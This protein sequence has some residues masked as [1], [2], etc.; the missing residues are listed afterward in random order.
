LSPD[1]IDALFATIANA[2]DYNLAEV[3]E[4]RYFVSTEELQKV[5]NM[6]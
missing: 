6:F 2:D 1:I 3:L 5:A 4:L